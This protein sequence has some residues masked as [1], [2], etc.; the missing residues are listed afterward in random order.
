MY[1]SLFGGYE[2]LLDQPVAVDSGIDFV[3]LTDDPATVSGTWQ[4]RVVAPALPADRARSSRRPKLLA[5]EYLPDYDESLYIDN[6]VL[7]LQPPEKLFAD[8]LPDDVPLA[9]V[10]HSFRGAVRDEFAAVV[11]HKREIDIVAAEQLAHYERTLPEALDDQTLWGAILL[12]RHHDPAMR[13]TAQLWWEHLLRYSRRDQL[14]LPYVLRQTGLPVLVHELLN[15]QS[16]YHRW[17]RTD[18]DRADADTIAPDLAAGLREQLRDAG[19]RATRADERAEALQERVE[20]L[21]GRANRAERR[22]ERAEKKLADLRT[23]T[24]WRITRPLRALSALTR[25]ARAAS[26]AGG[27]TRPAG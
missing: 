15:A 27:P 9:L 4:V 2:T 20:R 22:A 5:H 21:R 25:R 16:P 18:L 13:A 24:S 26:R 8:L 6:S 19:R 1:T 17:P 12:R 14:S 23:S 3:A 10:K 11:R 7:L